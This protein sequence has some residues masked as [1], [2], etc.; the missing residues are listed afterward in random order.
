MK[1]AKKLGLCFYGLQDNLFAYTKEA[2]RYINT[3]GY[4]KCINASNTS[5]I[6][7]LSETILCDSGAD[8][9]PNYLSISHDP[10]NSKE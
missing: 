7:H 10:N 5:S 8:D 9:V 4:D 3:N 6:H 2:T 1:S